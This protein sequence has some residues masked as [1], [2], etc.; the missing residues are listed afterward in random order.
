MNGTFMMERSLGLTVLENMSLES[1]AIVEK[2]GLGLVAL[3]HLLE[4][5]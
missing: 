5:A 4:T 2:L 1:R 3:L